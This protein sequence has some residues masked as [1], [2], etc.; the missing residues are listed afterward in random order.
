MKTLKE[1]KL[2]ENEDFNDLRKRLVPAIKHESGKVYVGQRGK[3]HIDIRYKH[4]DERGPLKGEAG[5]IDIRSGK[6]YNKYGKDGLGID[7]T[8][9][10]P[11]DTTDQMSDL[12]RMRKYGTFEENTII[13][14]GNSED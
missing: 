10:A 4:A 5:Y 3:Q 12:A 1:F 7:S 6:F 8:R 13:D 9:L 11:F 2:Q 14:R